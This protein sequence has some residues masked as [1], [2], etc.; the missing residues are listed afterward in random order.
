MALFYL[1]AAS[2]LILDQ[3][4]KLWIRANLEIGDSVF[5]WGIFAIVRIPPNAGAA[6]G[7]FKDMSLLLTI[8][9]AAM[10][11]LLIAAPILLRRRASWL[12]NR[13]TRLSFGLVLGGT[14]GNLFDRIQPSL[15]GV[16][17]FIQVGWWPT[18]NIA[19]S[20]ISVGVA[21]FI[22]YV[23]RLGRQGAL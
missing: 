17:D 4:T 10:A 20:A 1:T 5:E 6:F 2:V 23:F 18:F 11:S 16:T 19:D 8:V 7:L 14:L 21:I 15:G 9:A 3:V 22:F 13:L 12:N